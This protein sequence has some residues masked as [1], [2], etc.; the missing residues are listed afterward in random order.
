[1]GK[2]GKTFKAGKKPHFEYIL[3]KQLMADSVRSEAITK[4]NMTKLKGKFC[5]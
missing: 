1:M 3:V 4:E 5:R 2:C